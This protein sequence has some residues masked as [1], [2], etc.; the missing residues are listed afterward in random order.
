MVP[1]QDLTMK[2]KTISFFSFVLEE[3]RVWRL[4]RKSWSEKQ[5]DLEEARSSGG[6]TEIS[7]SQREATM[8]ALSSFKFEQY[9]LTSLHFQSSAVLLIIGSA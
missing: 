8:T 1:S 7:P 2:G 5:V 9:F 3:N 6:R 4:E